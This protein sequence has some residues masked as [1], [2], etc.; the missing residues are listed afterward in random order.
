MLIEFLNQST[1][2]GIKVLLG[3]A[4]Q[5]LVLGMMSVLLEAH[6]YVGEGGKTL[7]QQKDY[8]SLEYVYITES[9]AIYLKRCKST[10]RQ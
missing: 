4:G 6:G 7:H 1:V 3:Q 9:S 10:I 5:H 2:G 8:D